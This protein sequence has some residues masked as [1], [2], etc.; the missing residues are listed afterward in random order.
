MLIAFQKERLVSLMF[1]VEVSSIERV[2]PGFEK[3]YGRAHQMIYRETL[4]NSLQ[5]DQLGNKVEQDAPLSFVSWWYGLANLDLSLAVL[6]SANGH[7]QEHRLVQVDIHV[8]W[9]ARFSYAKPIRG[10]WVC[11]KE[12]HKYGEKPNRAGDHKR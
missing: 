10:D 12:R 7:A 4:Q 2:L 11:Q 8:I 6:N 1:T 3:T 5:R 9:P